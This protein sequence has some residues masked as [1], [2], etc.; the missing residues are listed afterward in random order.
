LDLFRDIIGGILNNKKATFDNPESE[1][2]YNS[3]IVNRA[4]SYYK[5]TIFLANQMNQLHDLDKTC[6]INFYLNTVR[7]CKRPWIKWAKP[8]KE[9][10][11]E[12]VKSYYGYSNAKAIDA[13]KILSDD[14]LTIIKKRLNTGE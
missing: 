10:D 5:D 3:F 8:I 6:Q 7:A 11:L 9:S 12:A 2:V 14:Q 13:L 4:L 1:R